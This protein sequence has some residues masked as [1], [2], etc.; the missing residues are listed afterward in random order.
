MPIYLN[1]WQRSQLTCPRCFLLGSMTPNT[2]VNLSCASLPLIWSTHIRNGEQWAYIP[3]EDVLT[4]MF[5]EDADFTVKHQ[6]GQVSDLY[7]SDNQV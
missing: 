6:E 7:S 3:V 1:V 5:S 2:C 4:L